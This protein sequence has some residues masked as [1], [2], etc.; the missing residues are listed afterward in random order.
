VPNNEGPYV[1]KKAFSR[2][3]LFLCRMDGEDLVRLVN[4]DSIKILCF[5]I[6]KVK[7]G[8]EFSL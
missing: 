8:H 1:V 6:N 3:A 5:T 4:A 2:G 7:F